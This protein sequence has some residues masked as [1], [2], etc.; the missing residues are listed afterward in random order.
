MVT[1]TMGNVEYKE[2]STGT[3]KQLTMGNILYNNDQIITKED[4]FVVIL[5]IDDKT[6][7]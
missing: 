2:A 6:D 4:G 3:T 5:Y 7:L 1:K